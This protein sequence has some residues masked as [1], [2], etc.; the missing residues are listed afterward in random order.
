MNDLIKR[1]GK[2]RVPRELLEGKFDHLETAHALAKHVVVF[3]IGYCQRSRTYV[4]EAYSPLFDAVE[5]DS[6]TPCYEIA[7]TKSFEN[8]NPDRP[9]FAFKA[10]RVPPVAELGSELPPI[11]LRPAAPA[12]IAMGMPTPAKLRHPGRAIGW[13]PYGDD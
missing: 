10:V 3:S 9:V 1:V 2:Y 11:S 5:E 6:P 8:G 4:C 12:P 13:D 7:I